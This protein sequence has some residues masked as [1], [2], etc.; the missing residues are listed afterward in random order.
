MRV[1]PGRPRLVSRPERK[2]SGV[3]EGIVAGVPGAAI[4]KV[5]SS[6]IRVGDSKNYSEQVKTKA[7]GCFG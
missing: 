4:M 6:R 2:G 3:W 1:V 7:G 5:S